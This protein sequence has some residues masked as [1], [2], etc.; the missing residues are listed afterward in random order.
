MQNYMEIN[1]FNTPINTNIINNID[2]ARNTNNKGILFDYF[3][4]CNN[5]DVKWGSNKPIIENNINKD[6][7]NEL[8]NN[9]F[10]N[11]TKR[12]IIVKY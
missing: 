12:K 5:P 4:K 8:C 3:N 2:Y 11:N 10:N 9:L 7:N 1:K 6:Y